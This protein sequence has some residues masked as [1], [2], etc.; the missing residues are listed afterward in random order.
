MDDA[1]EPALRDL[2]ER[3]FSR[4]DRRLGAGAPTLSAHV[5]AWRQTLSG[6]APAAGYFLHERAFP[7]LLLPWWIEAGI[8]D[9]GVGGSAGQ[10]GP[11][12]PDPAFHADVVYSTLTGY[13]FV[14][15]IDDLMDHER[16]PAA[17]VLPALIFFHTEFQG[18]YRGH[19]PDGH[20][21]WA[22]FEAASYASAEAASRDAG[23]GDVDRARFERISARKISGGKVPISAVCHRYGRADL[24]EPWFAFVDL[25][26]CWHQMLNDMLDWNRDLEQGRTTYFLSEASRQAP[27][28]STAEWVVSAG[29]AWGLAQLEAWMTELLRAAREL[30]RPPL[31]AY[32]EG[33]QATVAREWQAIAGSLEAITRLA[34]VLR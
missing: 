24:L 30:D 16:P 3:A 27:T 10:S 28:L 25:L 7:M 9:G 20:P 8:R 23:L 31:V 17:E 5:Q 33:R 26:G 34:R 32:L 6:T 11:D 22:T 15:M 2:V 1:Y 19:F 21:F 12:S 13:Y 29:L 14:R 4:M 18:A